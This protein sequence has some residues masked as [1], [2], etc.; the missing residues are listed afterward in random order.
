MKH[1]YEKQNIRFFF[2]MNKT[3]IC[4][5]SDE[6]YLLDVWASHNSTSFEKS[7]IWPFQTSFWKAQL[8]DTTRW[9][10]VKPAVW[11]SNKYPLNSFPIGKE[12][13]TDKS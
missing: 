11:D 13:V 2:N 12:P 10:S 6:K 9:K 7:L 4:M 1:F 8:M 3:F 5:I